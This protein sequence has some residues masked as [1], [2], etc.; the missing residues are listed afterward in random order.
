MN[1]ITAPISVRGESAEPKED[2]LPALPYGDKSCW[3]FGRRKA[4]KAKETSR[5]VRESERAADA[6]RIEKF[7]KARLAQQIKDRKQAD[8][9]PAE[10]TRARANSHSERDKNAPSV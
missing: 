1:G 8:R 6:A 3:M 7:G 9:S 10:K 5:K 2:R 4:R